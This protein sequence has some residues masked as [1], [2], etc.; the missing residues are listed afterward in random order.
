V[1]VY[2]SST[3][4]DLREHRE[5]V[6]MSLRS[7]GHDVLGMEQYT[8]EDIRPLD[9]CLQDV[10][11]SDV[12]VV[13]V[14]WRYG[15]IPADAVNR[16]RKRSITELEY[17]E[18]VEHSV[19]VLAFLLDPGSPWPPSTMDAFGEHG[20]K[21]I[22]AF[23]RRLGEEKLAGIFTTPDNL[24]RQ[25]TASIATKGLS[26]KMTYLALD[27]A[28]V[29]ARMEPFAKGEP[30]ALD[31]A[32]PTIIEMITDARDEP[33]LPLELR[34]PGWWST[35]LYLMAALTER[36]T[37]VRQLVFTQ[38]ARFV[39]M[40]SPASVREALCAEFPE[41]ATFHAEMD[42][43]AAGASS[44]AAPPQDDVA[45]G[46]HR[47]ANEWRARMGPREGSLKV[48]VRRSLLERWLGERLVTRCVEVGTELTMV[49][50]QQIVDSPLPDVPLER[51]PLLARGG[52]EPA[53]PSA[54]EIVIVSRDTFAVQL[55]RQW[56]RA[57]IP[58]IPQV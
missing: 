15:F 24:A 25:V 3:L 10:R 36:L 38:G 17:E 12:Y 32:I 13:I 57:E 14:A 34:P 58:R 27:Q 28:S 41:L 45:R 42:Q 1:K 9:R 21:D 51:P 16:K 54:R 40:A 18:A 19:A 55:A 37:D 43:R 50:V 5:T 20:A 11:A 23:R 46:T 30:G 56:V 8:A 48:D 26:R 31:S 2:L 47:W 33:A 52:T 29:A 35:R 4:Q 39:G 7:M 44:P 53:D 49:D 22:A 6:A